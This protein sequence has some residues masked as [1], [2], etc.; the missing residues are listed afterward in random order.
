MARAPS[1]FRQRDVTAALRAAVA[2]GM[3]VSGYEIDKDGKIIV[4]TGKSGEQ[5]TGNPLIQR[6]RVVRP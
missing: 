3:E 5:A 2:A 1:A 4:H 6:L